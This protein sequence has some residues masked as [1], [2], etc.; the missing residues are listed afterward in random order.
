VFQFY[1]FTVSVSYISCLGPKS[2]QVCRLH[3]ECPS[4]ARKAPF[5]AE[6]QVSGRDYIVDGPDSSTGDTRCVIRFLVVSPIAISRRKEKLCHFLMREVP[7][8]SR[9]R[10]HSIIGEF[11]TVISRGTCGARLSRLG[12]SLIAISRSKDQPLPIRERRK[13]L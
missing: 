2:I 11:R 10:A 9:T 4:V 3:E 12:V 7:R 1:S 13:L 5:Q 8:V 6:N